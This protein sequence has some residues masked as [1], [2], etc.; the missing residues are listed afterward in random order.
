MNCSEITTLAPLYLSGELDRERTASVVAHLR[1]CPACA[2]DIEQQRDLDARVRAALLAEMTDAERLNPRIHRR[3]TVAEAKR[4]VITLGLVAAG[5]V[6]A[7]GFLFYRFV[8]PPVSVLAKAA[9]SDHRREVVE[10]RVKRWR[11]APADIDALIHRQGIPATALQSLA[12]A[13]YRLDRARLCRLDGNIY[14]HL[15]YTDGS[16]EM[17]VFL[18]PRKGE[19]VPLH[20]ENMGSQHVVAVQSASMTVVCVAEE[21]QAATSLAR[22]AATL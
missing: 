2:R 22:S 3:I 21:S 11:S 18:R 16:R 20:A 8:A 13:G 6:L 14:L 12:A 1:I 5:I 7:T 9:V 19:A 17:S 4:R 10:K 15:V